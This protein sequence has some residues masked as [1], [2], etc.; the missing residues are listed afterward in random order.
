MTEADILQM[1]PDLI[2]PLSQTLEFAMEYIQSTEGYRELRENLP[3]N[4]RENLPDKEAVLEKLREIA[5]REPRIIDIKPEPSIF[6]ELTSTVRV[7]I[8]PPE[9]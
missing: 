9:T 5:E 3:D 8:V 1:I 6:S 2:E 7:E 4:L